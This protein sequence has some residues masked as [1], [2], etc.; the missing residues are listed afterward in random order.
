MQ[1]VILHSYSHIIE[2]FDIRLSL[3]WCCVNIS[4]SGSLSL[5]FQFLI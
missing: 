1:M 3:L 5:V 2:F 4:P